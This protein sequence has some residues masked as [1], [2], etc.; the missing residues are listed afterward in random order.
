VCLSTV[1]ILIV[2]I[3]IVSAVDSSLP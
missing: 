2:A 3:G 1:S